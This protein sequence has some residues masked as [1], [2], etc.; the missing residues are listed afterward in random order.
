VSLRVNPGPYHC[1]SVS[2]FAC[3]SVTPCS[4]RLYHCHS[5]SVFACTSVTPC[6]LRLHQC[7]SVSVFVCTSVTP[8]SLRLYQCHSVQ[9]SPVPVTLRAVFACTSVSP[10]SFRSLYTVIPFD[11]RI[12]ISFFNYSIFAVSVLSDQLFGFVSSYKCGS[13]HWLLLFFCGFSQC[14]QAFSWLLPQTSVR[15]PRLTVFPVSHSLQIISL[16]VVMY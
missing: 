15:P 6:S 3:T 16:V 10:H 4:L 7:Y 14:L 13:G 2:F 8:C 12:F 11:T 1:H 9:S 5:V